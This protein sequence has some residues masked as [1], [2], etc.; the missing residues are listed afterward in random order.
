MGYFILALLFALVVLAALALV[1]SKRS[2]QEEAEFDP[3]RDGRSYED[4]QDEGRP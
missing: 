4:P 1:L 2:P 3:E